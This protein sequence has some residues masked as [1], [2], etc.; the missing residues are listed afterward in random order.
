MNILFVYI[1]PPPD[2]TL[3]TG[4]N[5]GVGI[6]LNILGNMG[7]E[8][9]FRI[10]YDESSVKEIKHFHD[11]IFVSSYS[12]MIDV[13]EKA[14]EY[15]KSM[16]PYSF[17][18]LGGVHSTVAPEQAIEIE[19][20]DCIVIGEGEVAIKQI[21][22]NFPQ[23]KFEFIPG[24]KIKGESV[25][26]KPT[27]IENLDDLPY[28]HR[29]AFNQQDILDRYGTIVGAEFIIG[30]GCPY[31]CT[32]CINSKL[33]EI[34]SGEHIRL[35]SPEYIIA[36][37]KDFIK[38][39][40]KP[41]LIGFHDDI[42]PFKMEWLDKFS[43]L[44]TKEINIPF[45]ANTRVGVIKKDLLKIYKTMGCKRLHIGV[46][47]ANENLRKSVLHRDMT[48]DEIINTFGLIKDYGIKT[49]AF[50][51]FGIPYETEGTIIETITLLRKIKPFR[52]II[53]LFTPF[54]GTDLYKIC[55]REGWQFNY[56]VRNFYKT[57]PPLSQPSISNEILVHYFNNAL[58]MIYG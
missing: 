11:L 32:Y 54:P 56:K 9:D 4:M 39:Y 13:A 37:I 51:M 10:I 17:V 45:W 38:E 23:R 22:E 52:T 12:G 6:L 5:Q 46:E 33:N 20:V 34:Y 44:Y 47:T 26:E 21:V 15:A 2:D 7:N 42:F 49:L 16:N 28:P 3:Y 36:E 48:N 24:L 55:L 30:R 43:Y 57:E 27:F 25:Y 41:M 19:G 58:K 14:I 29:Q 53:S 1:S 18:V 40:G 50:N 8:V 31:S 35:K